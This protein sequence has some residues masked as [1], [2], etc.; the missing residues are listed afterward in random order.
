MTVKEL[1][2]ED[3]TEWNVNLLQSIFWEEEIKVILS[4]PLGQNRSED[5][6]IWALIDKCAFMVTSAYYLALNLKGERRGAPSNTE[7]QI[8]RWKSIWEL[9][10]LAKGKNF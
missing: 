5:K 7:V 10:V 6:P 4:I 8:R 3:D 2:V 9:L 1:L